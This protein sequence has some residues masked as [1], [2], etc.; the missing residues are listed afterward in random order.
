MHLIIIVFLL[1]VV[2]SV[3]LFAATFLMGIDKI[4]KDR[5]NR[6]ALYRVNKITGGSYVVQGSLEDKKA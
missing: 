6:K 2:C 3:V 5:Q 1:S 4:L